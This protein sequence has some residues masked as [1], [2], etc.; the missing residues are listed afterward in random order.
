MQGRYQEAYKVGGL[1]T[2]YFI[3]TDQIVRDRRCRRG[4]RGRRGHLVFG[5]QNGSA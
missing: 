5:M 4:R 2:R 3:Q 1:T